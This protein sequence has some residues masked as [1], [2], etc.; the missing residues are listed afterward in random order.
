MNNITSQ[1]VL[2]EKDENKESKGITNNDIDVNNEFFKSGEIDKKSDESSE[3][4]NTNLFDR[5]DWE[6]R[7]YGII[8]RE[9]LKKEKKILLTKNIVIYNYYLQKGNNCDNFAFEEFVQRC[10][11][12]LE[13]GNDNIN[14]L[15]RRYCEPKIENT[16]SSSGYINLNNFLDSSKT[17]D[18]NFIQNMIISFATSE[19]EETQE[20]LIGLI[21]KYFH[22][23][24]TLFRDIIQFNEQLL[25][26]N[27]E[28][29]RK[30]YNRGQDIKIIFNQFY[31]NYEFNKNRYDEDKPDKIEFFLNLL[32]KE[33]LTVFENIFNYWKAELIFKE[34]S[35]Y[36]KQKIEYM[37][38]KIKTIENSIYQPFSQKIFLDNL[39]QISYFLYY[40]RNNSGDQSISSLVSILNEHGELYL[41]MYFSL[42][43]DLI[44]KGKK[45][46]SYFENKTLY[47]FTNRNLMSAGLGRA[48]N[49]T[50]LSIK[51]KIFICLILLI[52]LGS[53]IL[54]RD[55]K[56]LNYLINLLEIY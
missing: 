47:F 27:R 44:S 50:V 52:L 49:D 48:S 42:L 51:N 7:N 23:R 11:P 30:E 35:N 39:S 43:N 22:Q 55:D 12:C 45:I 5:E 54:P 16:F 32:I 25:P 18:F 9:Y 28:K 15:I 4:K 13:D 34:N 36:D 46:S 1:D 14:K 21:Y 56:A 29:V 3:N 19:E 24:K 31:Q 26:D 40:I 10:I 37:I 53:V 8:T 20:I 38:N 33:T 41:K 17:D 2:V 6:N